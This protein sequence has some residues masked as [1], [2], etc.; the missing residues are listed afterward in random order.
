[1]PS[2]LV[3]GGLDLWRSTDGGATL[4]KISDWTT[5][6]T[7]KATVSVHADH[8]AIV[9]APDFDGVVNTTVYFGNDGGLYCATNIYTVTTNAGWLNLNHNLAITQPYG[10]AANPTTFATIIG[11]QDNGSTQWEPSQGTTWTIWATGDGGFCAADPTDPNY[12]YGEY[13]Y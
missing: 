8:H 13:V 7:S 12:F 6:A 5:N 4:T 9:S 1:N 10:I 2:N 3:V 11:S